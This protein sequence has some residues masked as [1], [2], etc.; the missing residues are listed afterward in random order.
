[1]AIEACQM[2]CW[3]RYPA[4]RAYVCLSIIGSLPEARNNPEGICQ[5]A[6]AAG[7]AIWAVSLL[8]YRVGRPMLFFY[9]FSGM[10]EAHKS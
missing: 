3:P 5:P 1:M 6:L 2:F 8:V 7:S 4:P 10:T 9:L